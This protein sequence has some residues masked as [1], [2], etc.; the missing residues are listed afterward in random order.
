MRASSGNSTEPSALLFGAYHRRLLGLLLMHP[1]R[2]FHLREVERAT[3]VP[4]GP[5][6]REL[7]RMESAGLLTTRRVGNQVHY[8]ANPGCPIFE[9]LRGIVRKTVGLGDVLRE[10]LAPIADRI[11]LAF[12][13]GSVAKGDEGPNSDIDLMVVGEATFTEVVTA[14]F[15]CH[16]RVGRQVN[17]VVLRP[18]E[19]R[20]RSKENGFVARVLSGQKLVLLGTLDES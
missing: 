19:F 10:A 3:G 20:Q 7:K 18:R 17:P 14:L 6:H 11:E 1:D 16:E 12:V 13:F 15:P 4:S 2:R 8:Q 9:E 5:A